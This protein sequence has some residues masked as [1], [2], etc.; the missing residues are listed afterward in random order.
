ML[1]D[2]RTGHEGPALGI[3]GRGIFAFRPAAREQRGRESR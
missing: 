2:L 1:I 3:P